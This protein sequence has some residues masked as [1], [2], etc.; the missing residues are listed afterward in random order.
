MQEWQET[1]EWACKYPEDTAMDTEFW[2]NACLKNILAKA[3]QGTTGLVSKGELKAP[4]LANQWKSDMLTE[5]Y[6]VLYP[7][8]KPLTIGQF[9]AV[10]EKVKPIEEDTN[11]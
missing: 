1:Y 11:V 4:T 8:D 5:L 2:W 6:G 10:L 3:F 7:G 9:K